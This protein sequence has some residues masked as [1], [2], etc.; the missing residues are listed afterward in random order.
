[1]EV[2]RE[3]HCRRVGRIAGHVQPQLQLVP[4]LPNGELPAGAVFQP[5]PAAGAAAGSPKRI[6]VACDSEGGAGM[7]EYWART[8]QDGNPRRQEYRELL[9]RECNAAV[10]GCFRGGATE[11]IVSDDGMGGIMTVP[12]MM[13][14]RALWLRGP[15]FGGVTPLMQ[16]LDST[17]AGVV[18]I[19]F[20]A[21]QDAENGV[22]AHTYSSAVP[23]R[24]TIN[25]SPFGEL[26]EYALAAGHDH[27][28]PVILVAGD[29]AVCD[30][31][32]AL[33]GPGVRTVAVKEGV[34][35]ATVGEAKGGLPQHLYGSRALLV[36]PTRARRLLT[37]ACAE[38]VSAALGGTAPAMPPL[39]QPYRIE[40]KVELRL[41]VETD[42]QG[43][44]KYYASRCNAW[45]AVG[46]RWPLRPSVTER[47][48]SVAFEG[49]LEEGIPRNIK[50]L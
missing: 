37:D 50:I 28:V 39:P 40:G 23:R 10:E 4:H 20:H 42:Q 11:V 48:G 27:Q 1:M 14:E 18:L 19:G 8:T 33:L 38:A 34:G 16:G 41:E 9:T 6:Y 15:G 5:R 7:P 47:P 24:Q 2:F 36:A 32:T 44:S 43:G 26:C 13:D 25:G 22:L 21:M 31:A 45:E 29:R 12:E 46:K 35:N 30:E 3:R 49:V 17:F